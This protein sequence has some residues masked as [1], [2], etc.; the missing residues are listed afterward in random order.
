MRAPSQHCPSAGGREPFAR[1]ESFGQLGKS[2]L[3]Q[4]SLSRLQAATLLGGLGN[5]GSLGNPVNA[6]EC[7]GV[8]GVNS[9]GKGGSDSM[10]ARGEFR[11]HMANTLGATRYDL[12][13][14]TAWLS[15]Y[16]DKPST[17]RSY[18]KEVE[19]FMLWCAQDLQKPLSSVNSPDCQRYRGFPACS[20]R[21]LDFPA[22][23][24]SA[25]IRSGALFV[26]R[27]AQLLRNKRSLSCRRC[28]QACASAGYPG[29]QSE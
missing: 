23:G 10:D 27:P 2:V 6:A 3:G 8:A 29:G 14:V 21:A 4:L 1:I 22:A 11:S 9:L 24:A 20:A 26:G 5:L 15:R 7:D 25:V 28:L 13:A 18:R 17:Q 19:R 12:E 16:Q